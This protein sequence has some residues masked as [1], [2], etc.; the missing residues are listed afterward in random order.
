MAMLQRAVAAL[1]ALALLVLA[2]PALAASATDAAGFVAGFVRQGADI[3]ASH[4]TLD[5]AALEP[6]QRLV[7]DSLDLKAIAAFVVGPA[8]SS[9]ASGE[10]DELVRLIG[11]QIA[12]LYARRV[13][14]D[15]KAALEI[16]GSQPLGSQETLV[17]SR[18]TRED[19]SVESIDWLVRG[20]AAGGFSIVDIVSNGQ[21]LAAM[22]RSEYA[23]VLQRNRGDIASLIEALRLDRQ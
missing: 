6:W 13:L 9:A 2:V 21:S 4:D 16:T 3:A 19:G 18:L 23:I 15:R 1:G 11:R 10:R 20:A 5:Q 22:K 7:A 12:A 17:S 8:W 14:A